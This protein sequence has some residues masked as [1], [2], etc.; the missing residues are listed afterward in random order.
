MDL[1]DFK[2]LSLLEFNGPH[3]SH[4]DRVGDRLVRGWSEKTSPFPA[5]KVLR[6]TDSTF[7]SEQSFCYVSKFPSLCVYDISVDINRRIQAT[8][9]AHGWKSTLGDYLGS[10][11]P[12]TY[13][14]CLD[15]FLELVFGRRRGS[16]AITKGVVSPSFDERYVDHLYPVPV[17]LSHYSEHP[18]PGLETSRLEEIWDTFMDGEDPSHEESG[19]PSDIGLGE[20]LGNENNQGSDSEPDRS[21]DEEYWE[22]SDPYKKVDASL[23]AIMVYALVDHLDLRGGAK[24]RMIPLRRAKPLPLPP[25]PFVT[26]ELQKERQG[27]FHGPPR[28]LANYTFYRSPMSDHTGCVCNTNIDKQPST[29]RKRG[30]KNRGANPRKRQNM[31]DMLNSFAG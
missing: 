31:G 3:D 14:R 28:I 5:L 25:K 12:L 11:D 9:R 29:E 10:R 26:L 4:A 21:Q 24:A 16:S 2:N 22:S 6:I 30:N 1:A 7:L 18:E 23:W 19:Q 17:R 27:D 8:A 13:R 15:R 20:P